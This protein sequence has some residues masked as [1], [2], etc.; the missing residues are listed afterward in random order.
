MRMRW[1]VLLLLATAARAEPLAITGAKVWTNL[2][3]T[4]VSRATVVIDEGR[5]VSITPE[6]PVPMQARV[7]D[8]AGQVI[9]PPLDAAATQIGLVE[10]DSAADTDDR[11]VKS[12]PLG[13]AFDISFGIDP[14]SLSIQ[15]ARAAGVARAL[16]FPGPSGTGPFLGQAA[17]LEIADAAHPLTRPRVALFVAS[18]GGASALAGGSRAAVW[19]VVRNALQEARALKQAPTPFRPRDQLQNHAEIEAL[20]PV[21]QRQVPL[22]VIANRE[23]DIRQALALAHDFPL[24]LVIL[25]AAEAWRVADGIAAARVPVILDPLDELP[26]SFDVLGARRDNAARLARA[27]VRIAFSISGQGIYLSHDVGAALREGAGVAA[28][29]GLPYEEALRAITQSASLIWGDREASGTLRAGGP[30]DLVIWDGDPL[31]PSSAPLHVLSKGREISL[32][33]RQT[34]LRDRYR[35]A[36]VTAPAVRTP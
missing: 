15:F 33:T 27:G 34:L 29:N 5:I 7:I 8:A 22:A 31:E 12:G 24:D 4:P 1:C 14:N 16:V 10:L 23:A 28:A 35:P 13:A 19:G 21:L 25:G 3:A 9:T 6:G 2:S 32:Q 36:A 26:V 20:L 17:R 11:A 18:G 30:A